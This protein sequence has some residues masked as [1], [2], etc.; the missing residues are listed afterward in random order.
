MRIEIGLETIKIDRIR[1][2]AK[3]MSETKIK[4]NYRKKTLSS[5]KK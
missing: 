2:V 5:F 1:I 4:K 3:S